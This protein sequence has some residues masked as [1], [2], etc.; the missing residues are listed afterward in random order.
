MRQRKRLPMAVSVQ[1]NGHHLPVYN[2]MAEIVTHQEKDDT[3]TLV[4]VNYDRQHITDAIEAYVEYFVS[5]N[6]SCS[7]GAAVERDEIYETD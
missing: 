1:I 3:T 2:G 4:G 6:S 5:K 7:F